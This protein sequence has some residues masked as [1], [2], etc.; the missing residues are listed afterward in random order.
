MSQ[1]VQVEFRNIIFII[2]GSQLSQEAFQ[3]VSETRWASHRGGASDLLTT[4]QS[5]TD[6]RTEETQSGAVSSQT[7]PGVTAYA[8]E[9]KENALLTDRDNNNSCI[10]ARARVCTR[11]RVRETASL[12]Q[13]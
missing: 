6:K 5:K 2:L 8:K 12:L 10:Y 13:P 4:V 9:K 1:D 7:P 3:T 11:L